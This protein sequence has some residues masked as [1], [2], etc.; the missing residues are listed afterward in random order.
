MTI[1]FRD[2]RPAAHDPARRAWRDRPAARL[3]GRAVAAL[4]AVAL[5]AGLG[6][7][8]WRWATYPARPDV[9]TASEDALLDYMAGDDFARLTD[10]DKLALAEG[11]LDRLRREATFEEMFRSLMRDDPRRKAM[12]RNMEGVAGRDRIGSAY[13]GLFLDKYYEIEGPQRQSM[14]TMLALAQ[15]A[16]ITTAPEKFG[17]PSVPQFKRDMGRFL[18]RQPPRVQ[19]QMGQFLI[20]L[21]QRRV[22]MGLPDPF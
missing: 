20:D 5:V 7:G 19:G 15:Q 3:A 13:L 1:A 12:W 14:L 21:K 16:V 22:A 10:G 11:Y 6:Y 18:S 8:A 2:E 17:L 9:A 4:L